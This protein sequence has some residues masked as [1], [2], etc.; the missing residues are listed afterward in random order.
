MRALYANKK[1]KSMQTAITYLTHPTVG[2]IVL[3]MPAKKPRAA[4][5]TGPQTLQEAV[6][7]FS[8]PDGAPRFVAALKWPDGVPVCPTC[9]QARTTFLSTRH[10]WKCLNCRK[11]FSVKV[12]TIFED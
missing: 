8:A 6:I 11:Q 3:F 4:D 5:Q 1:R 9:G 7:Y 10:I 2:R 12:G